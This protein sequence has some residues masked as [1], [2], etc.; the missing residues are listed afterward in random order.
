[1]FL[2]FIKWKRS[3]YLY[4]N[5]LIFV[6]KIVMMK[7]KRVNQICTI[8]LTLFS[9]FL[10]SCSEP[11][12]ENDALKAAELTSQSNQYSRENNFAEAGRTYAQ[13][14]EIMNKYKK[15]NKFDEFYMFYIS[16]MQ[17]ATYSLDEQ[18]VGAPQ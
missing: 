10:L 15:M 16:Y 6:N 12:L 1:M 9:V 5:L 18:G 8:L 14:Q 11:T 3:N 7:R 13:V 4:L 2:L 17:D